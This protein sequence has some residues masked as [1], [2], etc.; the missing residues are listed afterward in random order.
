[1]SET[2]LERKDN[3][4]QGLLAYAI[5]FI[6]D[7]L[8][9]YIWEVS[10]TTVEIDNPNISRYMCRVNVGQALVTLLEDMGK[11]DAL[12][13]EE[14]K[15]L[16]DFNDMVVLFYRDHFSAPNVERMRTPDEMEKLRKLLVSIKNY[17]QVC[18]LK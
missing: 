7:R 2:S 16:T 13:G 12:S 18:L 3:S 14:K 10:G 8:N 11:K 9:N 17:L 15:Q 1:M 5:G 6:D 4:R